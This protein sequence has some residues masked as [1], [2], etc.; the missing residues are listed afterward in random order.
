MIIP[1]DE[2]RCAF[3]IV[4]HHEATKRS[5]VVFNPLSLHAKNP[6]IGTYSFVLD[7]L[8][9]KISYALAQ[10]LLKVIIRRYK[11]STQ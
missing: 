10:S 7:T 2:G 3:C 1:R 4:H 8:N 11:E 6:K 9:P 5:A